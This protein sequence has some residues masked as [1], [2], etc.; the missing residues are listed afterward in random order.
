[1]KGAK[2]VRDSAEQ[3]MVIQRIRQ[4]EAYLDDL[5][6]TLETNPARIREDDSFREMLQTLIRYYEGG[7]WLEDYARD[8]RGEL[9]AGLKRGVLSEDA[10]YNLLSD[11]DWM[12]EPEDDSDMKDGEQG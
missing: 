3:N 10:V 5:T 9:P 6:A 1:M 12:T 8:E 11:L 7:E 2:T 4:M